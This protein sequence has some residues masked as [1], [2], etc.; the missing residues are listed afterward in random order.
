VEAAPV[1]SADWVL[2]P[3]HIDDTLRGTPA[4]GG[5]ICGQDARAW[6]EARGLPATESDVFRMPL[7]P[8]VRAGRMTQE[9]I[10]W[11]FETK[12][13][14]GLSAR[15]ALLPLLS[16]AEIPERVEFSR[17]FA[18]RDAAQAEALQE[19]FEACLAKGDTRVFGQD[20]AALAA[21]CRGGGAGLGRWL[22]RRRGELL[23]A[24]NAPEQASRFLLFLSTLV[25]ERRQSAL[26]EAGYKR[27]RTS[28]IAFN[29]LEKATPRLALKDDQIVWARS[30]AR[31]DLAGGWTD[32][33]PY[34]L[35]NG[36]SVL[37][38]A[39]FLNGQPPIQVFVRPIPETRFRLRSI[40]LGSAMDIVDYGE[41]GGFHDPRSGFNLPKAALMLAG[42]HPDFAEGR[43]FRSLSGRLK[44]FGGGLEISLLS[45]V[46]KG[47]GLGTSSIL[48]ATLLG[49]LNRA[50]GLGW[51]EIDLY[52]RVLGVEQLLT[53]GGG[54]QD[55]AGAL[56]RGVKLVETGPGA[57]QTPT[58]RYLPDKLLGETFANGTMQLYYTGVTRLA[59][60]ILKEIVHDMFLGRT[61]T[62]RTLNLIRANARSVYQAILG[63]DLAA[64]ERS[65]GRSWE[66]NKRLDPGTTTPQIERII[67]ACGDD[68]A[69]CKLL[70]AGGG[71]YMLLAARDP[72]AG[73]R[74]RA[75]LEARPPNARA[76]FIGFAVSEGALEVTVS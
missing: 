10:D 44:A 49:A 7:Y 6:L 60:G 4:D 61:A 48:G 14:P 73:R 21:F 24:I 25:P 15:I 19:E 36:G 59:K 57:D 38:V 37:N 22:L 75:R 70:G 18:D 26:V 69:A 33:P 67:A 34:C 66:L 9:L 55:Q 8:V 42:F 28:V 35:E 47:S 3:Y 27:L 62:L 13:D 50:C 40:D 29:Q 32:T 5:R 74:I 30:P 31:L 72:E 53:T 11:Y 45:A 68:L 51:D 16:A 46:P 56:F 58:V 12:P 52:R 76:R 54:W 1:G 71:G 20:F 63:N 41:L 64:L 43:P 17:L 65:L 39:V 2:R 23:A